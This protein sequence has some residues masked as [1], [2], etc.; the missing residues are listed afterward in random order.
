MGVMHNIHRNY[1][2]SGNLY[3]KQGSIRRLL[4]VSADIRRKLGA[5]GFLFDRY[6]TLLLDAADAVSK[7]AMSDGFED[8]TSIYELISAAI[9]N[10]DVEEFKDNSFYPRVKEYIETHPVSYYRSGTSRS[11]YFIALFDEYVM[12]LLNEYMEH[13]ARR[14]HEM[15]DTIDMDMRYQK[16][17]EL[18]GDSLMTEFSQQIHLVFEIAPIA[19]CYLQGAFNYL[20]YDMTS[21]EEESGRYVLLT[22][23][24]KTIAG[25]EI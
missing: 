7:E 6:L 12:F 13:Q 1:L 5:Q 8:I 25:D 22:M 11:F 19:K 2:G 4:Q 23:I 3:P 17:C 15:I 24:D 21:V 20:I 18:A 14:Q 9:E 16:L 10:K